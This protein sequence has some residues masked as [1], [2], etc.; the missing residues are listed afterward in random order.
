MA[1]SQ[2]STREGSSLSA[3]TRSRMPSRTS[4]LLATWLYSDI[5]SNPRAWPSLRIVTDSIPPSSASS[6]AVCRIRSRLRGRRGSVCVAIDKSL[7]RMFTLRHKLT[8]YGGRGGAMLA[9]ATDQTTMTAVVG[10][11]YGSPDVLELEEIEK[12]EL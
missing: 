4:S 7:R 8:L 5:A 2:S 10:K 6:R 9:T 3:R 1:V 12:P 11:T